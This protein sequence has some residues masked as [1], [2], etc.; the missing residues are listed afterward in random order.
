ALD[1]LQKAMDKVTDDYKTDT[2][3]LQKEVGDKNANGEDVTPP[4]EESIPYK[5]ALYKKQSETGDAA[6]A[7][8]SATKKLQDYNDK[9]EAAK[10]IIDQVN[11]PDPNADP[12]KKPTNADVKKALDDLQKAKKA[13]DDAFTTSAKDLKTEADKSKEDGEG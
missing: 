13:I 5:N 11:N 9:F 6:T 7:D 2:D 10:K 4:F 1:A 8:T 3:P 12:D